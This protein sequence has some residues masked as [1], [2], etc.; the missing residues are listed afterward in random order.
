MS[1]D[2]TPEGLFRPHAWSQHP[3]Q[4]DLKKKKIYVSPHTQMYIEG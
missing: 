4:R 1:I 2:G 3:G